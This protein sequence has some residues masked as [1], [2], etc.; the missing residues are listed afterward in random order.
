MFFLRLYRFFYGKVKVK[1]IGEFPERILNIFAH[2]GISVWGIRKRDGRITFY[3][4]ARDFIYAHRIIGGSKIRL[5]ILKKSGWP[6][7]WRRYNRRYGVFA[8]LIFLFLTLWILS[9]FVWNINI[10]GN[11]VTPDSE[12]I[13]ALSDIGIYEGVR[14]DSIDAWAKRVELLTQV[15]ELAWAALNIEGCVLTVDVTEAAI[16]QDKDITPCNLI[17]TDNGIIESVEVTDGEIVCKTG[18]F[19]SSG[20]VLVSGIFELKDG[21]THLARSSGKIYARVE[22]EYSFTVPYKQTVN[23]LNNKEKIRYALSFFGFK[24]P[25]YLGSFNE[26]FL[27]TDELVMMKNNVSYVPIYLHKSAFREIRQQS[28]RISFDEA[29]SLAKDKFEE[30]V[31]GS[32]VLKMAEKITEN[33]ESVTVVYDVLLLKNIAEQEKIIISATN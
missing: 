26:E 23:I 28:V 6:F 22:K 16:K 11:D 24:I 18:D 10:S 7:I 14:A 29:V 17:A 31:K 8:G 13:S 2:N 5:H 32:K 12:I 25:L 9:G 33:N 15:D 3:M 19:V 20:D 21:S 4:I 27:R 1:A 30:R